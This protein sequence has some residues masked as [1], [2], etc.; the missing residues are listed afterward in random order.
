MCVCMCVCAV[1]IV[2]SGA[3]NGCVG[4]END[5]RAHHAWTQETPATDVS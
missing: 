3:N 4:N 1:E 2:W 5:L